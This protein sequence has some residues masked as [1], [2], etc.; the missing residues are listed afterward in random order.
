VLQTLKSMIAI[1]PTGDRIPRLEAQ[2]EQAN[3]AERQARRYLGEAVLVAEAGGDPAVVGKA[4]KRLQ[5]AH[6]K[7]EAALEAARVATATLERQ[8]NAD[9]IVARWQRTEA[10]AAERDV[11]GDSIQTNIK[12]LVEDFDRLADIGAEI[13]ATCPADVTDVSGWALSRFALLQAFDRAMAKA[14]FSVKGYGPSQRLD[15]PAFDKVV[16]DGSVAVMQRRKVA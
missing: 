1:I 15:L 7:A 6:D 5:E 9:A 3:E 14:G 16:R 8:G 10:L 13:A 12:A 11:L 2:L 4:R